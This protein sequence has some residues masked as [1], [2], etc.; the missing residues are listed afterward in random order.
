MPFARLGA[1]GVMPIAVIGA[2]PTVTVAVAVRSSSEASTVTSPGARPLI[3]AVPS[4][5][6]VT[7]SFVASRDV[8]VTP[9][10]RVRHRRAG[11]GLRVQRHLLAEVE[12][13]RRRIDLDAIGLR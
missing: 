2:A 10:A 8:Q 13:Y 12:V 9:G 7:W 1:G 3:V 5:L 11:D 4:A 6:V